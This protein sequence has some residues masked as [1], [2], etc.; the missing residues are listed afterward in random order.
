MRKQNGIGPYCVLSFDCDFPRD[1]EVLPVLVDLLK[2]YQVTASFACIGRWIREYPAP[3]Q[4]L[5][6]EG[7]EILNHT[8]THPNLYHPDYDYACTEDLSRQRFNEI[9]FEERRLEIV[10]CHETIQEVLGVVP[11]GFRSP[12]FGSLHVEDIYGVLAECGYSYSSS[13]TT[14]VRGGSP[15]RLANGIWEVPVSPCPQHP[16]G[17]LDSWHSLAKHGASHTAAGE[18]SDLFSHLLRE[19]GHGGGL[20]NV[21]FDPK[22]VFE[23]GE[24]ERMLGILVDS[25]VERGSYRDLVDRC[26]N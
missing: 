4:L 23:S 2:K 14:A 11:Q 20:A 8:E 25:G 3:H 18:L 26:V 22:D 5:V 24:M 10:R 9:S 16:F 19:V 12:H 21:Y 6:D 1:I 13:V 17:V 7:F 15:Y